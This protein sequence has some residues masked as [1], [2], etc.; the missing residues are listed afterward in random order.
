[1]FEIGSLCLKTA[2]RDSGKKCTVIKHVDEHHVI[3]DGETR[4]RK[5]NKQH[6]E[7]LGK[8]IDIKEDAPHEDIIQA[9]K[10]LNI[11]IKTPKKKEKNTKPKSTKRKKSTEKAKTAKKD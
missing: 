4:R 11:T 6:L 10:I 7:P 1:M 8:M 2:G 5:C 3:I 9:F